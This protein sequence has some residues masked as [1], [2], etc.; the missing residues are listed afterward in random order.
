MKILNEY[1]FF[2]YFSQKSF[3]L[4]GPFR[5]AVVPVKNRN[6]HALLPYEETA[7]VQH[8]SLL[9]VLENQEVK[10]L[11]ATF[12]ICIRFYGK[13][14]LQKKNHVVINSQIVG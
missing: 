9:K 14:I 13:K 5:F 7:F 8:V 4:P 12:W 6:A 1:V 2:F 11:I 3:I 10:N